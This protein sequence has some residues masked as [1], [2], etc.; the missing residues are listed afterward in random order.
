MDISDIRKYPYQIKMPDTLFKVG[1]IYERKIEYEDD[2]IKFMA[3]VVQYSF[4]KSDECLVLLV[5][6]FK[7]FENNDVIHQAKECKIIRFANTNKIL[8]M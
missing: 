1:V 5:F 8:I 3:R 4:H 2:K 6:Y 7:P